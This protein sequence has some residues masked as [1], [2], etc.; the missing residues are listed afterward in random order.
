MELT[1]LWKV[2]KGMRFTD[3]GLVYSTK[4]EALAA[5]P[6]ADVEIFDMQYLFGEDGTVSMVA[7]IPEGISEE[8]IE[9]ALKQEGVSRYDE[10]HVL[11]KQKEGWKE[12]DGKY[13]FNTGVRGTVLDEEVNPWVEIG[14][15]EEGLL[16]MPMFKMK[17]VE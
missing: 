3:Q 5:D 10:K 14:L 9:E 8:E 13:F 12:E 17:K 1:G 7:E 15:D 2:E 4:E 11:M 16:T 6:E